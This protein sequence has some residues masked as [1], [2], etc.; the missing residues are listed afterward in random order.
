MQKP[1]DSPVLVERGS[2]TITLTIPPR[3]L[4]KGSNG[5]IYFAVLWCLFMAVFTFAFVFGTQKPQTKDIAPFIMVPLFWLIGLTMLAV[6]INL[7]RRRFS[8]T[9]GPTELILIKDSPF[10]TKRSEFRRSDITTVCSGLS[11]VEV[12]HRR[13]TQL[14]VH[15]T[16]GKNMGFMAGRD[17]DELRW[18]GTE[19]RKAMRLGGNGP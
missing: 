10:G 16:N 4:N 19:L 8:I 15:L 7:G 2:A 18:M 13:L 1:A 11:K 17:P 12:N 14:Q 6:S 5:L 3:G 9:A